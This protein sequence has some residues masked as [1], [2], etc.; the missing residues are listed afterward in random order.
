MGFFASVL[1]MD[2]EMEMLRK[3][4]MSCAGFFFLFVLWLYI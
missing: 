3:K 2:M 1:G 4:D